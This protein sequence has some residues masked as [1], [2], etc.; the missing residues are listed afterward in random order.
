MYEKYPGMWFENRYDTIVRIDMEVSHV[1]LVSPL[2][3]FSV[4]DMASMANVREVDIQGGLIIVGKIFD[5]YKI[6]FLEGIL[7]CLPGV[8]FCSSEKMVNF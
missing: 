2:E 1:P 7:F 6:P 3:N 8:L 5:H 4:Y